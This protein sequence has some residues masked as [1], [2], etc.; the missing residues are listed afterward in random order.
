MLIEL[1]CI[2]NYI[3]DV[4]VIVQ[5]KFCVFCFLCLILILP[6]TRFISLVVMII[7]VAVELLEHVPLGLESSDPLSGTGSGDRGGNGGESSSGECGA[8]GVL[9][10]GLGFL[11]CITDQLHSSSEGL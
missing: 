1:Q 3:T 9:Q 8:S 2:L 10:S 5:N 6:I 7:V 4:Q 11:E